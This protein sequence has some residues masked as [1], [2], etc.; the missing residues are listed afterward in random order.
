MDLIFPVLRAITRRA[1]NDFIRKTQQLE[2]VQERFLLEMLRSHE[3]TELGKKFGL[4]KITTV[5]QFRDRVPILP[6]SS[7]DPYTERIAKG[8]QNILNPDPVI[9]VSLTSGSTGK[10]KR[11]PVTRR[12]QKNLAKPN[13]AAFGFA[14][15]A[16]EKRA[17]DTLRHHEGGTEGE[18]PYHLPSYEG[19]TEGERPYH[20]PPYEGGKRSFKLGKVLNTNSINIQGITD[21]GI[22]YGP[23][24]VGSIR[25]NHLMYRPLLAMP[26]DCLKIAD[27]VSRHYVCLLFALGNSAVGQ[28]ANNFP[29]LILRTCG[30]LEKYAAGLVADLRRG[31][32]ADWVKIAPELRSQLEQRLQAN[33]Q[34]ADRL[35]K[36]L[37]SHGKLTP[38]L[39]WPDL[40]LVLTAMG[41]TSDFYFQRFPDYFGDT[42]IFGGVYGSAEGTFGIGYDLNQ[43]GNIL[44]IES[45]FYE[46]IPEEDW[47]KDNP[48]TLLPTEVKIG[49]RYRMLVTSYSGI[50]RYDIGDVVEIL[51]FYEQT[52]IIVF[53][54]RR[55]GL[56]SATTEKTTEFHA[57]QVMQ[58]LSQE[59]NLDLDDFCITLSDNEFPSRYLVNIELTDRQTLDDPQKFLQRFEYW[60]GEFNNPYTTVRSSEVPPPRL[61]ILAP[62]SFAIVRQRQLNK[63]MSDGHLKIPHIS[64]DRGFLQGLD[65]VHK[66]EL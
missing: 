41:G 39:A 2:A 10:R 3:E 28:I 19:G 51:G 11:I 52:P 47:D 18:R 30:Y 38:K 59:F 37:D 55:G 40:A 61:Q 66:I 27:S 15:E 53:R 24:T 16:L 4:G 33:P 36:I 25:S 45:G 5:E 1:K 6:Y 56:L 35:E 13:L 31:A 42:P 32:I 63:G 20:L 21:G 29:M 57:T 46:F 49:Q 65:V 44:S 9:Y 60:L 17:K 54:H 12:Y 34:C 26:Y 62:G 8:E 23:V 50:Y 7:Y 48:T 14:I 22:N 64:E 58:V 43:E